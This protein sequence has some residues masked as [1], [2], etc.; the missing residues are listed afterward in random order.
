MEIRTKLKTQKNLQRLIIITPA[1]AVAV[2]LRL[3]SHI[4]TDA[5]CILIILDCIGTMGGLWWLKQSEILADKLWNR[6]LHPLDAD[7]LHQQVKRKKNSEIIIG[8]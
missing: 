6:N 8:S 7:T 2:I 4:T 1:V 5:F 3:Y